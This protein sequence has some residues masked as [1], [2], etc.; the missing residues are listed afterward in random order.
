MKDE[1][2]RLRAV[3]H[4]TGLGRFS[5]VGCLQICRKASSYRDLKSARYTPARGYRYALHHHQTIS[6]SAAENRRME[7]A[8]HVNLA[9]KLSA[10][11]NGVMGDPPLLRSN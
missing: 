3:H 5:T 11:Q 10:E 6:S 2:G 7:T 8:T 1:H 9:A 4:P